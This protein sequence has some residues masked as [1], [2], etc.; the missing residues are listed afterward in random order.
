MSNLEL[1]NNEYFPARKH[2]VTLENGI[3]SLFAASNERNPKVMERPAPLD[4]VLVELPKELP[5]ELLAVQEAVGEAHAA[6]VAAKAQNDDY[7]LEEATWEQVSAMTHA[8]TS[9]GPAIAEET[10]TNPKKIEIA[11][12]QLSDVMGEKFGAFRQPVGE[13]VDAATFVITAISL[14]KMRVESEDEAQKI[15]AGDAL[16]SLRLAGDLERIKQQDLIGPHTGEIAV[17]AILEHQ[18]A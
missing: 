12:L 9:Y 5:M 2:V 4:D 18:P 8:V 17:A 1:I 10:G 16:D 11:R 6:L 7:S 15:V 3:D 13:A 14:A